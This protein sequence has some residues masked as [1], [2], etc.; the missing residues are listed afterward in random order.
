MIS[1]HYAKSE[2]GELSFCVLRSRAGPWVLSLV[3]SFTSREDAHISGRRTVYACVC[4]KLY[5]TLCDPMDCSLPGSSVHWIFQA[6]ILEWV[7]LP[8]SR[9]S[10]QPRDRTQVSRI[11]GRFFTSWATREAPGP[12][13]K[14]TVMCLPVLHGAEHGKG[15]LHVCW[16]T[17]WVT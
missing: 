16:M 9:G 6:R 5:L 14:E 13:K 15:T 7:V 12:V 4:V 3:L 1:S 10:S 2:A 11:A 17:S 8:F